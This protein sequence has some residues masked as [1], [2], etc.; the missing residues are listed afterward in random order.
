VLSAWAA[1]EKMD[2]ETALSRALEARILSM[3]MLVTE[4]GLSF[5]SPEYARAMARA[6]TLSKDQAKADAQ[7]S[8]GKTDAA[9][10]EAALGSSI[11][12]HMKGCLAYGLT[13]F[14][15][16]APEVL[17][18]THAAWVQSCA[19]FEKAA[20]SAP[21]M[22]RQDAAAQFANH[23]QVAC[24]R[25]HTLPEFDKLVFT[26]ENG[27]KLRANIDRYDFS[28]MHAAHKSGTTGIDLYLYATNEVGLL[29]FFG[30]VEAAKIGWK[31]QTDAWRRIE[32][33]VKA[34][35]RTWPSYLYE[36]PLFFSL[37]LPVAGMMAAGEV[38]MLRD[39][40]RHNCAMSMLRDPAV[41]SDMNAAYRSAPI[42]W[43]DA[44]T[45]DNHGHRFAL[46]ASFVLQARALA[47]VL[48]IDA[49]RDGDALLLESGNDDEALRAWLPSRDTLLDNA[50]HE[51]KFYGFMHGAGH[52]ALL[53]ATLYGKRLGEWDEAAAIAEGFLAIHN[54]ES[55]PRMEPL[56]RIEAWRLL[57]RCHE[58]RGDEAAAR[59]ALQAAEGE[60]RAVGY[61][62]MEKVAQEELQRSA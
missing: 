43:G 21:D 15:G 48:D 33:A 45:D 62:F 2:A 26:G 34:G 35:E 54:A 20:Q 41:A 11:A 12:V 18:S 13:S 30:D 17:K 31:K 38:R 46:E 10:F 59:G 28:L 16:F 55:S 24:N 40:F 47:T 5:S 29:L 42:S 9:S 37:A 7:A 52:P 1:I 22:I 53:C 51:Y 44:A 39:Y 8:E 60:A 56:A 6:E 25:I 61:V 4:G 23:L 49:K 58:A 50:A 57:A 14:V 32:A 19:E 36:G 3:L 27:S